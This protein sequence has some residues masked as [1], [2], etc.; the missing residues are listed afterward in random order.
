MFNAKVCSPADGGTA[1]FREWLE[2]SPGCA[3]AHG[4]F[5]PNE[6]CCHKPLL[7]PCPAVRPQGSSSPGLVPAILSVWSL[8]P[9]LSCLGRFYVHMWI[10]SFNCLIGIN[11]S[12]GWQLSHQRLAKNVLWY[13]PL[14]GEREVVSDICLLLCLGSHFCMSMSLTGHCTGPAACCS[15]S[16]GVPMVTLSNTQYK[17]WGSILC[18]QRARSQPAAHAVPLLHN[19]QISWIILWRFFCLVIVEWV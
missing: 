8:C 15:M 16:W 12:C 11:W 3:G 10:W 2:T 1:S 17:L 5:S 18:C 6:P 9:C 4:P 19:T 7:S 13:W 14:G